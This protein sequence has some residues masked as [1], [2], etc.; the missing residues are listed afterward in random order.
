MDLSDCPQPIDRTLLLRMAVADL[1]F[2][3]QLGQLGPSIKVE[4]VD[5]QKLPNGKEEPK[6]K[7]HEDGNTQV[8]K[9][10]GCQWLFILEG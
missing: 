6:A 3:L 1:F 2:L 5:G 7:K 10:N 4:K 9:I 8:A